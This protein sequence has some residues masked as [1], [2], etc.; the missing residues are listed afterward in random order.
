MN[1]LAGGSH[2]MIKGGTTSVLKGGELDMKV[3]RHMAEDIAPLW[4]DGKRFAIVS[5]G[6]RA[7]GSNG[8]ADDP[9]TAASRG[10]PLLMGAYAEFFGRYGIPVGQLLVE[11]DHFS[12]ARDTGVAHAVMQ[13]WKDNTLMI[14]NEN[15][16][17]A[18]KETTLGDNDA[19]AKRT[20]IELKKR[21]VE[22]GAVVFLSVKV[23]NGQ[24]RAMGTG[25]IDAKARAIKGLMRDGIP[26]LVVDGKKKH[27]IRELFSEDGK[28][29]RRAL[30]LSDKLVV[31]AEEQGRVQEG[32]RL[33]SQADEKP[34]AKSEGATVRRVRSV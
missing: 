12:V 7:L 17:L 19:L 1:D 22:M 3:L 4:H 14:I 31:K 29:L 10:Q 6:A 18:T 13:A 24:E 23:R 20:A 9:R 33:P 21:G 2:F 27:V 8:K 34:V 25:G 11:T 16:P 30:R 5:S 28:E 15:D 26:A 32:P